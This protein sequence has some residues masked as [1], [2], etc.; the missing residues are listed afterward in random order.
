MMER[1]RQIVA[2][3][4]GMGLFTLLIWGWSALP[5]FGNYPGPNG[6]IVNRSARAE[7]QVQNAVAAVVFDYR[8]FDTMGEEFIFLATV[9]GV[10]LLLRKPGRTTDEQAEGEQV[11]RKAAN[12]PVDSNDAARTSGLVFVGLLVVLGAYVALHGHLSPG[13]GFQGGAIV[14]GGWLLIYLVGGSEMFHRLSSVVILDRV[15]ALGVAAF[16]LCGLVG[17]LLDGRFL[18][19]WMPLGQAGRLGSAG[20]IFALNVLVGITVG[21]GFILLLREFIKH[22]DEVAPRRRP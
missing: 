5:N 12:Q 15:E 21:A 8:G 19:N 6:D 2:L 7:R 13:G 22:L 11:I 9:M 14:A 20:T 16:I 1:F 18:G 3:V 10:S 4:L 17:W